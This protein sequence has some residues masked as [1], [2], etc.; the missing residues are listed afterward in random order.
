METWKELGNNTLLKMITYATILDEL[1]FELLQRNIGN[2]M[3]NLNSIL[4][5]EAS[6]A[7]YEKKEN[8]L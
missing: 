1:C 2:K 6:S 4:K 7:L 3:F 5:V 8:I